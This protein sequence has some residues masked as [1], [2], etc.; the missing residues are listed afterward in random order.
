MKSYP[1]I[2][3][4]MLIFLMHGI[5]A[6]SLVQPYG[7]VSQESFD[8]KE[9]SFEPDANAMILFDKGDVYFDSN[10]EIV[11]ERHK[12][13]K[14]FNEKGK[15]EADFRIEYYSIRGYEKVLSVQAQ[16]INQKDGKT[17]I[18]KLT[19]NQ[20]FTEQIDKYR[21]AI[22]FTLPDVQE[23]SILE[24]KY[25]LQT[26]SFGNF[27]GWYFQSSLPTAYSEFTTSVPDMITYKPLMRVHQQLVKNT[28][29]SSAGSIH[30]GGEVLPYTRNVKTIG[31]KDVPSLPQEPFMTSDN[32]NLQ[33]ILHQLVQIRP[34]GGFTT[35]GN[36]TWEKIGQM[37]IDD[38]DFGS[39]FRKKLEGEQELIQKAS[40]M[41]SNEAKIAYLFKE[42]RNRMKWNSSDRWYTNDGI[43]KAWE[44]RTGNST[45]LNLI[46]Y[47][48]LNQSGVKEALP[49]VVSTRD[50]GKVHVAFPWIY[51]FNRAVVYVPIDSVRYYI[52]DASDKANQYNI[53][54]RSLLNNFGLIVDKENKTSDT[55]F[56]STNLPS[57]ENILISG[58]IKPEGHVSGSVKQFYT[59]YN[60]CELMKRLSD[61]GK[62]KAGESL[63][64][65]NS[66]LKIEHFKLEEDESD[67]LFVRQGFDFDMEMAG[68]DGTY[69]YFNPNMFS[70]LKKNPFLKENRA[71]LIDFGHNKQH[72]IQGSYSIPKGFQV[73]ALPKSISLVMPDK[74]ITFKRIIGVQEDKIVS[75]F[76]IDFKKSI[77]FP[78]DYPELHEF[79]KQMYQML[80]EQVVLKKI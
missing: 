77:Y 40:S 74:S 53:V 9:C 34:I 65:D 57:I 19:N 30:S 45:E 44:K 43:A 10:F 36:D 20:K 64:K 49:M 60:R 78:E 3:M 1:F 5:N 63:S 72:F 41:T 29:S 17:V 23:G 21:S 37:L 58:E 35:T 15:G 11:Y 70:S 71:T 28:T 62:E 7:K 14:I 27:P 69:L 54:P 56:I 73:D 16:T 38:E 79:Y 66:G 47:R 22:V 2:M 39:Q 25:T 61:D 46:L 52:L 67:S 6:Q 18:T 24:L 26:S 55:K 12:R 42:V 4:S 59:L 31:L 51:Q 32:D 76:V 13:I 48:L 75:R 50:N 80:N 33:S 8:L 68:S